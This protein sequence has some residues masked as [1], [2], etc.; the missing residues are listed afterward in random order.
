MWIVKLCCDTQFFTSLVWMTFLTM[1]CCSWCLYCALRLFER[2]INFR[3]QLKNVFYH[4]F[5][6]YMSR[7]WMIY[8][9]P[10]IK[11]VWLTLYPIDSHYWWE[12]DWLVL[13]MRVWLTC[14]I[15]ESIH[16]LLPFHFLMNACHFILFFS[17]REGVRVV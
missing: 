4:F 10:L 9:L 5:Y 17:S 13:L 11:Q 8:I 2:V 14:I 16:G 6:F 15:D 12:Y 7:K 1:V 3:S